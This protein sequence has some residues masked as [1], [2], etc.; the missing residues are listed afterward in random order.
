MAQTIVLHLTAEVVP[1]TTCLPLPAFGLT[2]GTLAFLP[3]TLLHQF[4]VAVVV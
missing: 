4:G 3:A 2:L 1:L